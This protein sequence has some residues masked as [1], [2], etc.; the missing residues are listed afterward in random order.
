MANESSATALLM[1]PERPTERRKRVLSDYVAHRLRAEKKTYV[2]PAKGVRPS[3]AKEGHGYFAMIAK[4]TGFSPAHVSTVAEGTKN[5]GEDFGVA[6]A[7]HWEVGDLKALE[8]A[9][10]EWAMGRS[11]GPRDR[12]IDYGRQSPNLERVLK[13]YTRHRVE[14]GEAEADLIERQ[15]EQWAALGG[16][17]QTEEG[18]KGHLDSLVNAAVLFKLRASVGVAPPPVPAGGH[19]DPGKTS[20]D[21]FPPAPKKTKGKKR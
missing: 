3:K 12:V 4:A 16:H 15:A 2:A 5:V 14:L 9:A 10:E 19:P 11:P 17:D 8:A 20:R 7:T 13:S 6:L 21:E 18:W 1:T